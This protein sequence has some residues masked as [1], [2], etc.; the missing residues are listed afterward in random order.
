MRGVTARAAGFDSNWCQIEICPQLE[1]FRAGKFE[2]VAR[3]RQTDKPGRSPDSQRRGLDSPDIPDTID[4]RRRHTQKTLVII[5]DEDV[6][7]PRREAMT[8]LLGGSRLTPRPNQ[9]YRPARKDDPHFEAFPHVIQE[10]E[11]TW[12][13]IQQILG[14]LG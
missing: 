7:E 14:K 2:S 13:H 5:P 11:L 10:A 3:T 4:G 1:T 8:L 12:S 9:P 6:P